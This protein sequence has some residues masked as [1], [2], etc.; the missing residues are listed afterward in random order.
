MRFMRAKPETEGLPLRAP[1][2][3]IR[4][5]FGVVVISRAIRLTIDRQLAAIELWTCWILLP[6]TDPPIAGPPTFSSESDRV[7]GGFELAGKSCVLRGKV[8]GVSAGAF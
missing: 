6:S 2:E 4:E 8:A 3:N 7:A 1:F 5:V